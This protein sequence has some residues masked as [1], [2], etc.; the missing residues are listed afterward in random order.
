M[1]T[2]ALSI[3]SIRLPWQGDDYHH[4]A[5]AMMDEKSKRQPGDP[6]DLRNR[7]LQ[8]LSIPYPN[9]GIMTNIM[10][11]LMTTPVSR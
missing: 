6:P 2:F 1:L 4:Q 9:P 5:G 7:L 11:P 8:L 10:G 3:N